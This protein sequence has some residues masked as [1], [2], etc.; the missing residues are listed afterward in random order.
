MPSEA[1]RLKWS[2]VDWE[3]NRMTIRKGKTRQRT[4]PILPQ[5]RPYLEDCFDPQEVYVIV[6]HRSHS[7]WATDVKRFITKAGIKIWPR[8]F[9]NLRASL[10]TDLTHRF[11]I[12]VVTSWLGNSPKVAADHYLS[13]RDEDFEAA[14]GGA[15]GGAV[16]TRNERKRTAPSDVENEKT[17]EKRYLTGF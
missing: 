1:L 14:I 3:R 11:P 6:H 9:H 17:R 5:L 4:M 8:C 12:H 7:N 13:V 16:S 15:T 10:E 2:D